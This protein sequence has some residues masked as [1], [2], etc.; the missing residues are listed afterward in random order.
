MKTSKKLLLG[1]SIVI[2]VLFILILINDNKTYDLPQRGICAHRGANETHPENTILAFD[3]AVRLGAQMIEFDV[4]MTKDH[5]LIILHDA[6][7]DRTT[8]GTGLVEELNWSYIKQ[9]DAGDWKSEKFKGERIPLLSEAL[10]VFPR[11]IWL[12]VHL[13]GNEELGV[14][15]AKTIKKAKREHQVIIAANAA[16][17]IGIKKVATELR[18][19][20]MERTENRNTYI[21]ETISK[22]Y[23]TIQLLKHRNGDS[24][25]VY[26]LELKKQ[27]IR[28]NYHHGDTKEDGVALFALG[29]DFIL[30][31][32]LETL[33]QAADEIGIERTR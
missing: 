11:N 29:V 19:C 15:V 23:S 20:N 9:L 14:L 16:S 3:E 12:N 28:I 30:T 8:N 1:F 27:N 2:I 13:K 24:I 7:V 10:E 25:S 26:I 22:N 21:K 5:Q 31:D 17:A 32:H 6:S 4:R 18:I 33:L